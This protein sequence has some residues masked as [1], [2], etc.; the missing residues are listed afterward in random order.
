MDP[1]EKL[2]FNAILITAAVIGTIILFFII[3]IIRQQRRNL[4]LHR[5]NILAEITTLEKERTRIAADLHDELG[6]LLS[7]IK[8]KINSVDTVDADDQYQLERAS[9]HLDDLITRL[10]EIAANLMPNTL[11]RKGLIAAL[12]QFVDNVARSSLQIKLNY[13]P[14]PDINQEKSINLYRMVQEITHNTIKHAKATH[15][16]IDLSLKGNTLILKTEDNGVG[17]DYS[18][19]AKESTG[20]GLRNLKS[21]AEIMGGNFAVESKPGKGTS[22]QFEIPL[23]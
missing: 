14:L 19:R 6:P 2:L 17:F 12:H 3:S 18:N 13:P 9:S 1:Q 7:A 10:R 23:N 16:V 5:L 20:F 21:R 4:E 8:F 11:I 22:Y 15:L